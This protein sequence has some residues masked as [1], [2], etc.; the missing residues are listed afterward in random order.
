MNSKKV[1]IPL[2]L[3]L[4]VRDLLSYWDV[5]EYDCSIQCEYDEVLNTISKKLHALELREIY[6]KI[7]YAENEEKRFFAR[8]DYLQARHE[9]ARQSSS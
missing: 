4:K 6:S 9:H 7:V 2:N 5:L 3:L 1:L 8:M